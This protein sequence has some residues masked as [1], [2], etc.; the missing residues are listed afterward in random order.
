MEGVMVDVTQHSACTEERIAGL[1][2]MNAEGV[3]QG[4]RLAI[5]REDGGGLDIR[6]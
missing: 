5:R 3:D 1:V 4:G 6:S 2:E